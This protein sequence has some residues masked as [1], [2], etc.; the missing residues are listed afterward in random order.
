MGRRKFLITGLI[1]STFLHVLVLKYLKI[2]NLPLFTTALPIEIEFETAVKQNLP[3]NNIKREKSGNKCKAKLPKREHPKVPKHANEKPLPKTCKKHM[4]EE[5][6]QERKPN[7]KTGKPKVT[8]TKPAYSCKIQK[9]KEHSSSDFKKRSQETSTGEVSRKVA[10]D[11][12]ENYLRKV[13]SIIEEHK[14]YPYI[15]RCNEEEGNVTL[16]FT[17]KGDGKITSVGIKKSSGSVFLDKAAKKAIF[18]SSPLPPPPD[19]RERNFTVT[20]KFKLVG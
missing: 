20:I 5:T 12:T 9:V 8:E 13:V 11:N 7:L 18:D 16:T 15:S 10:Q 17:V 14:H 19:G 2:N 1:I 6:E 3:V 4:L